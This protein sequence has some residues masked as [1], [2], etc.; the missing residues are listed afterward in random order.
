M[1]YPANSLSSRLAA[2]ANRLH[3]L[4]A[5]NSHRPHDLAHVAA[6][7]GHAFQAVRH[8][9]PVTGH[10]V[11][12]VEG[13]VPCHVFPRVDCHGHRRDGDYDLTRGRGER[14]GLA[15]LCAHFAPPEVVR[16]HVD[17]DG[18]AFLEVRAGDVLIRLDTTVAADLF[19]ALSLATAPPP[20]PEDQVLQRKRY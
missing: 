9:L 10:G 4:T 8:A 13:M 2:T 20:P 6:E 7:A 14:L 15:A 16:M 18:I 1:T 11:E 3:R 5:H 17:D 12:R 19:L